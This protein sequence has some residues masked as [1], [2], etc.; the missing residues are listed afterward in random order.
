[1]SNNLMLDL[2]G[3]LFNLSSRLKDSMSIILAI[4]AIFATIQC[5]F[6]Y[7]VFKFWIGVQGFIL[8]GII[9]TVLGYLSFKDEIELYLI[10]GL[11]LGGLGALLAMGFYKLGV[12]LQ[13]FW[14]GSFLGIL[15]GLVGQVDME[16]TANLAI[17]FGTGIGIIGILL[18]KPLIILSTGFSGGLTLGYIIALASDQ[19]IMISVVAGV[20]LSVCGA[21]YQSYP[22]EQPPKPTA[23]QDDITSI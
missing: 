12:F 21:L 5:F 20:I 3:V 7:R 15:I 14:T 19:D 9:G 4:G 16:H 2:A 17:I 22:D 11:I 10:M 23:I 6:G 1:M 8:F 13:C 18:I